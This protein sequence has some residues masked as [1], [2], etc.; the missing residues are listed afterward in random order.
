MQKLPPIQIPIRLIFGTPVPFAN[1]IDDVIQVAIDMV[2]DGQITILA[3]WVTPVD[4][5]QVDSLFQQILNHALSRLEVEHGL[6][7][8]EGVNQEQGC[9]HS[10][11]DQGKVVLE[12][13]AVFFVYDFTRCGGDVRVQ[14]D[15]TGPP[16][17]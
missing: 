13:H 16:S 10:S 12:L 3:R 9:F 6:S 5:V 11:F 1:E 8:D 15:P 7:I 14:A 17:T 2:I 4:H